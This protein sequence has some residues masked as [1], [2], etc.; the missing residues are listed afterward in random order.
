MKRCLFAAN[1]F[2]IRKALE[3]DFSEHRITFIVLSC[4]QND[5]IFEMYIL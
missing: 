4:A 1:G 3:G 5:V 2:H